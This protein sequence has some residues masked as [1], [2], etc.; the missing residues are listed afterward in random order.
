MDRTRHTL[1]TA[2]VKLVRRPALLHCLNEELVDQLS[3]L[4]FL[5]LSSPFPD[6]LE[7]CF[8]VVGFGTFGC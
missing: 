4:N 5:L 3:L 8:G 2:L 7:F 6:F 1:F